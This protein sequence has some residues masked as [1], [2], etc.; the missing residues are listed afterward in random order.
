LRSISTTSLSRTRSS[1]ASSQRREAGADAQRTSL[2]ELGAAL[3]RASYG[4][5]DTA[6]SAFQLE[7]GVLRRRAAQP[8]SLLSALLLPDRR[9][10]LGIRAPA[11]EYAQRINLALHAGVAGCGPAAVPRYAAATVDAQ[12]DA[13]AQRCA[14]A[15]FAQS[16]CDFFLP[17]VCRWYASDFAPNGDRRAVAA[18]VAKFLPEAEKPRAAKLLASAKTVYRIATFDTRAASLALFPGEPPA[19]PALLAGNQQPRSP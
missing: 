6:V 15:A 18:A 16:T 8:D 5:A 11:A 1:T 2:L 19:A 10:A 9:C 7:H 17:S 4:V 13:A 14:A 12:L 3:N